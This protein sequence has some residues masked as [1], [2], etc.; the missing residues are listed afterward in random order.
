[1]KNKI[2][3]LEFPKLPRNDDI[4]KNIYDNLGVLY[5]C[6]HQIANI[7]KD[8][9]YI[10]YTTYSADAHAEWVKTKT[11]DTLGEYAYFAKPPDPF[12]LADEKIKK[13]CD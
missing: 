5:G 13:I 3:N 9:K 1:M 6:S 12:K 11:I 7:L 2:Y 8:E 10:S 4:F